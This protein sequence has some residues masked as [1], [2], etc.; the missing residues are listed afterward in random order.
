MFGI[1]KEI[2]TEEE[3]KVDNCLYFGGELVRLQPFAEDKRKEWW[4]SA[5]IKGKSKAA[6]NYYPAVCNA[7]VFFRQSAWE[8]LERKKNR[9]DNI[10]LAC[11]LEETATRTNP[12]KIV[13]D[14]IMG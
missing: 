7:T 12:V 10:S 14:V 4:G 9:Y 11:H 2:E 6:E 3:V 1:K 13:A 8:E 5:V